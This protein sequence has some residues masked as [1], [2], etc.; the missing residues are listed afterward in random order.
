MNADDLSR[1]AMS[2]NLSATVARGA[3]YARQQGHFEV[4]LEHMLLALCEDPDA[5]L[6]LAASNIDLEQLRGEVANYLGGRE[7][8]PQPQGG[9]PAVSA[10]LRRILDAAAAAARG[11][12]RREINGA[13]VL[14]AIVG[15]GKSPAAHL[16]RDQG[17]T[18]EGAIKALQRAPKTAPPS[19]PAATNAEDILA[20]ARARV[21]SRT[22]PPRQPVHD[23]ADEDEEDEQ[24]EAAQEQE[25]APEPA[26]GPAYERDEA[27]PSDVAAAP[28]PA[29]Q[30]QFEDEFEDEPAPPPPQP[31][32][33]RRPEPLSRKR[34]AE[35]LQP[36]APAYREEPRPEP[37]F[38]PA[39][40][41][42]WHQPPPPTPDEGG[43]A[44]LDDDYDGYG[45]AEEAGPPGMPA[46]APF[47][48]PLPVPEP[49][50]TPPPG[51][52]HMQPPPP[53]GYAA[54]PLPGD[55]GAPPPPPAI[56][57]G[58][59]YGAPPMPQPGPRMAPPPPPAEP[60]WPHPGEMRAPAGMPPPN[61]RAAGGMGGGGGPLM[62]R[63]RG[64]QP[65]ARPPAQ[66]NYG[67]SGPTPRAEIGQLVENI[68]RIM[69]VAVPALVEVR[70]AKADVQ[71]LAE[72]LQGGGAAYH[73]QVSITKA[74]SVRLRAPDGGFFIETASP[75][76]QWIERSALVSGE[77]YA[78]WRWHVTPREKGRKRLQLVISAR[79]VGPDGLTAER[80]LPDQVITVR[81]RTNYGKSI[82]R[83]SGWVIAAIVG[84]LLARFGEGAFDAGKEI[85]TKL[86]AS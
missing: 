59:E 74:M 70:I 57:S 50:W 36:P 28:M 43:M 35:R 53:P 63:A 86:I 65:G 56:P 33:Q 66:G 58:D 61:D 39:P 51:G 81:V 45:V 12:R 19:R 85:L 69:R 24:E 26:P 79:T 46:S 18:F 54:P 7:P 5:G 49:S 60:P 47:P 1:I 55:Y 67:R 77:D 14:A 62:S 31:Q 16:L 20:N 15:D 41:D 13:I 52:E 21:Q 83:W 4:T 27:P 37:R 6:V 32:P 10:D 48:P 2:S 76:T 17:L 75:E 64:A 3:D 8:I 40:A 78:S 71:S 84:G 23:D 82:L 42:A 34:L 80:A 44:S 9:T 72:G 22:A 25:P 11:G 30:P 29:P 38:D 73:H 68:P